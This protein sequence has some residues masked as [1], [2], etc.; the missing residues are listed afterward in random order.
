MYFTLRNH[1]YH[2]ENPIVRCDE[3]DT[4]VFLHR[5]IQYILDESQPRCYQW[6]D[7]P[8][9]YDKNERDA[10]ND[11]IYEFWKE[12]TMATN[13]VKFYY[14]LLVLFVLFFN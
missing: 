1:C 9:Y 12:M 4:E 2:N 7:L 10:L 5:C 3:Y 13:Q 8:L 6:F 11:Q 14:E